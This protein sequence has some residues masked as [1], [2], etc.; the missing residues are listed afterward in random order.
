MIITPDLEYPMLC[1]GVKKSYESSAGH[2]Q[3]NMINLNSSTNWFNDADDEFG[4]GTETVIPRH[5][6]LDIISV[7]QLE[8]D[9]ILVCYDSKSILHLWPPI[10]LH[11]GLLVCLLVCPDAKRLFCSPYLWITSLFA[12]QVL[13]V[14]WQIDSVY[15][16]VLPPREVQWP[17]KWAINAFIAFVVSLHLQ[18]T[19]NFVVRLI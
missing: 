3:L 13:A 16:C 2:L 9:T 17:P 6:S 19:H 18:F 14:G 11:E 12:S 1:I 5:D 4:D 15:I 8:K 7:T 10:C